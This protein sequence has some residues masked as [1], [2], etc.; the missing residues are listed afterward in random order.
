M[1][2]RLCKTTCSKRMQTALP[3][4][5]TISATPGDMHRVMD[6]ARRTVAMS[7]DDLTHQTNTSLDVCSVLGTNAIP[8]SALVAQSPERYV[9]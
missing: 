1:W 6:R 8:F 5:V 7:S 4:L 2:Q 9:A 3:N